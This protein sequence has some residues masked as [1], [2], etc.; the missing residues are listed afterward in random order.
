MGIHMFT[1]FLRENLVQQKIT[2]KEAAFFLVTQKDAKQI[3]Y[4]L[5][6][7]LGY[8]VECFIEL[9]KLTQVLIFIRK[10]NVVLEKGIIINF[11]KDKRIRYISF[12]TEQLDRIQQKVSAEVWQ[13]FCKLF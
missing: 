4:I 11:E 2:P 6:N 13:E 9:L 7:L 10:I 12:S 1:S 3:F 8:S 5:N